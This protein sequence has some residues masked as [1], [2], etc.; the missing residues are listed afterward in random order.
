M[1]KRKKMD[2]KRTNIRFENIKRKDIKR[3]NDFLN[4]LE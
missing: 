1:W 4:N 3:S 2:E